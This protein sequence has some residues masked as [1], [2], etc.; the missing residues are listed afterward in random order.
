MSVVLPPNPLSYEGQTTLPYISKPFP[1]PANFMQAPVP[2]LWNDTAGRD[3]YVQTY[4]GTWVPIGG[5]PG[6]V[7]TL[8]GNTGGA[9]SPDSSNNI[10]ILGAS[11]Q[12]SVAGS[13]NTLTISLTG[14]GEAID[15][16]QPDSGTN[17]VIPTSAGLVTMA[18]SALGG[19]TTV[20]GTNTLTFQTTFAKYDSTNLSLFVPGSSDAFLISS[21]AG[22]TIFPL[23]DAAGSGNGVIIGSDLTVLA[24][25]FLKI[26][27]VETGSTAVLDVT[28]V[29]S[30]T[31]GLTS[32]TGDAAI[33]L[34]ASGAQGFFVSAR[35]SDSK[36]V[37]SDPNGVGDVFTISAAGLATLPINTLGIAIGSGGPQIVSGAGAPSAHLPKGS[38]YLNTSGS[39]VNDRAYIATDAAGTWTPV[40]T[41]G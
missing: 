9:I 37:V 18:G 11:G 15:S 10:N 3:A 6:Q 40:V 24:S 13:G 14:G 23:A 4:P 1:P 19:I 7:N 30:A 20:G 32:T 31:M 8:T 39:G 38:I 26:G 5:L 22:L 25:N 2:C 21:P 17:P 41:V 29:G 34:N 35:R 36:F 28:T 33:I 27:D 16:F 12:I